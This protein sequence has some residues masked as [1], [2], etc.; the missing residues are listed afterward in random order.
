MSKILERPVVVILIL[1]V[2][3][4]YMY[5]F[6]TGSFAL[7][8]PDETFYAQTAKEM[9][10]RGDWLTPY[11]Y[12]KPQFEKPILFYWLVEAS[13]KIFGVNE[14]AARFP[15]GLFAFIGLMAIYLLGR[16]LFN[17]R[18][19][20]FSAIVLATSLEYVI[21]GNACVTDMLLSTFML[22]GVLFFFYGNIEKRGYFYIL[23][24][25][26]FGFAVLTKG[27]IGLILPGF[28]MIIYMV[29]TRDFAIFKNPK[30]IFWAVASFFIVALP[31]YI[32]M[33]KMH[34]VSFTDEFFGF[35]NVTRFLTPEHKTG[36]ELYYNIPIV[37]GGFI[38]WS[39]FLPFGMW[40][41]FKKAFYSI[42]QPPKERNGSIFVLL[43]FFGIF[44]FFSVS[45]TKLPTYVFPSFISLALMVGKFWDDFLT[46][47]YERSSILPMKLSYCCLSLAVILGL[48]GGYIFI[49]ADSPDILPKTFVTAVLIMITT[50][51]SVAAF[52][53]KKFIAAF[54]AVAVL[55]I[56]ILPPISRSILPVIEA[57]ESS[58]PISKVIMS[59]YK[60]GDALASEK[61]YMPGVAF[62]TGAIPVLISHSS[63]LF[64]LAAGGRKVWGVL[65]KKNTDG[66]L[67]FVYEY[68]K[69]CLVMV[70]REGNK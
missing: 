28:I 2:L 31:W 6:Q 14:F 15:S 13:Y 8:D 35:H 1:L 30:A 67:N 60:D 40:Y 41:F 68:G 25:A 19:G 23:S 56:S 36:S 47:R 55:V 43:W 3:S 11:L 65:K 52:M 49:K 64:E 27:P 17:N 12:G 59:Y 18:T 61:D 7:T 42:P 9:L 33:Y 66:S 50:G 20:I 38:P 10:E 24:A 69:K 32:I 46:R 48:A 63:S 39:A 5:L 4:V 16:L 22:L 37:L 62:Y 53:M 26:A 44:I 54:I 70:G 57:Y 21:L 34:G 51:L 58:K 29:I 45:S